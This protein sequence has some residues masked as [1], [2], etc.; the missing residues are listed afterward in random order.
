MQSF[1][2]PSLGM[3]PMQWQNAFKN[4]IYVLQCWRALISYIPDNITCWTVSSWW[5]IRCSTKLC[6]LREKFASRLQQNRTKHH[7]H[8]RSN[9]PT[10]HNFSKTINIASTLHSLKCSI[11]STQPL[12]S[13]PSWKVMG[14]E[15]F[16][17]FLFTPCSQGEW[18]ISSW[19]Q[20]LLQKKDLISKH[21]LLLCR[22][23]S[24]QQFCTKECRTHTGTGQTSI[25]LER[26]SKLEWPSVERIPRPGWTVNVLYPTDRMDLYPDLNQNRMALFL[27]TTQ[28]IHQVLSYFVYN[29]LKYQVIL[30]RIWKPCVYK[31]P[32][33]P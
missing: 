27:S 31:Q 30:L 20:N 1:H 9:L 2:L 14:V 24:L 16:H 7:S 33:S 11:H 8:L 32:E 6:N 25:Q 21:W 29:L 23:N 10:K 12:P 5:A 4:A 13:P 18:R 22:F 26:K 17:T 19:S 28:L 15:L 3:S